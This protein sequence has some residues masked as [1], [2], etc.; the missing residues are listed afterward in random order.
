MRADI[1]DTEDHVFAIAQ[2]EATRVE[3]RR[4]AFE[5]NLRYPRFHQMRQQ[6]LVAVLA[7]PGASRGS[8]SHGEKSDRV[9]A[10][11]SNLVELEPD[12]TAVAPALLE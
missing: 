8:G 9:A 12:F 10:H 1:D 4:G 7:D 2:L 11:K 3:A 5:G 6:L